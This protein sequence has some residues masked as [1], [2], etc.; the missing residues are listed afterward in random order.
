MINNICQLASLGIK[1]R[2]K[3]TNEKIYCVAVQTLKKWRE[4][5]PWCINLHSCMT[6]LAASNSLCLPKIKKKSN[7]TDPSGHYQCMHKFLTWGP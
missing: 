2:T 6:Y 5:Y 3:K 4:V 7:Y 1:N